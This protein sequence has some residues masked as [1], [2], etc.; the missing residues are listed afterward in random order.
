MDAIYVV[1]T[2]VLN[3][4]NQIVDY[5]D[6]TALRNMTT[7]DELIFEDQTVRIDTEEKLLYYEGQ[8]SNTVIPWQFHIGY[9]LDGQTVTADELAGAAGFLGI[10]LDV[11]KNPVC[12]S[13]F[14]ENHV[15]QIS[16]LL[17]RERAENITAEDAT[18]A[19]V[20][21]DVQLSYMVLP[22]KEAH[23]EITADVT[24]FE[25]DGISINGIHMDLSVTRD[26]ITDTEELDEKVA[27]MQDGAKEMDEGADDL[28]EGAGDLRDGADSLTEGTR[29]AADGVGELADGTDELSDGAQTLYDGAEDL[30]DGTNDLIDGAE[31]MQ[32]GIYIVL[33]GA[34]ELRSGTEALLDGAKELADGARDLRSGANSLRSGLSALTAQNENLQSMSRT[35]Y[36]Q[37]LAQYSD[38]L[39]NAGYLEDV[40]GGADLS[41]LI[42]RRIQELTGGQETPQQEI[43][44]SEESPTETADQETPESEESTQEDES[45]PSQNPPVDLSQDPV[46]QALILLSYYQ[47]VIAYT[48]GV[49]SAASGASSLSSGAKKLAE[50]AEDLEEGAD[51]LYTGSDSMYDGLEELLD[52]AVELG[53]GC[54]ALGDGTVSLLD[55]VIELQDGIVDAINDMF[56]ADFLPSSFTDSRNKNVTL[57]QFVIQ[58]PDITTPEAEKEEVEEVHLSWWEKLKALF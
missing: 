44:A 26:D 47:G 14:F 28:M 12:T 48:N 42:A 33:D 34:A 17:D 18:R 30:K 51:D 1:N 50:G 27:E 22:G 7:N 5:G 8:L 21:G 53:D 38:A 54:Y 11:E 10:T 46:Y 16:L 9:E 37:T 52:G 36:Q 24:D 19:N 49:F 32:D 40:I 58:T 20:G 3:E 31:N 25:M 39:R 56:G 4:A 43:A 29:E 2:F 35:L 41:A 13:S 55:G 45:A 15:L 6:Y 57:V 23:F